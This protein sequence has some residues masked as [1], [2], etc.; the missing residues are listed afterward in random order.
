MLMEMSSKLKRISHSAVV[1]TPKRNHSAMAHTA[2][3]DSKP[4]NSLWADSSSEI[5]Y[6]SSHSDSYDVAIIGGG[7]SGLWSAYHLLKLNPDLSIV[8]FEAQRIGFGA[9]GRNGGW[10]SS[11]YPVY[12]STDLHIW[13]EKSELEEMIRVRDARGGL[14]NPECATINPIGLV[15]GLSK[16]LLA[17]GVTICESVYATA[18]E[19]GVLANSSLVSAPI[20]IQATEVFGDHQREFIPLYSLMVATQPLTDAQWREI[21][22]D[23]RFTFAEGSHLINY[24]Q[25]TADNRLA[26]GGR[27]ATYPLNS[28]LIPAKEM[29][30][31]V[32]ESLRN[33]AQSWFPALRD[34]KFTHAWGGAV[35]ITRNWEPYVHFDFSRG[36]G[37]LGGYA[38]DGVTMSYLA[39]KILAHVITGQ[40]NDLTNLHFV[41]KKIRKWEPE[42]LRYIAVNSMVKLSGIADKEEART[43]RPS[44]VSRIIAP[45]ILR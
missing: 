42:P 11:D 23:S 3:P 13:K 27:G 40:K 25:R 34:V 4:N 41:N 10:A 31:S 30:D 15:Q 39:S 26:I 33:L 7:F 38:G 20:V 12:R 16:Y 35:A 32:H 28:R 14:F 44:L 5:S 19:D 21:G 29:T 22:V 36:F 9:S 1:A 6:S 17:K 18:T 37:R 2:K 43:G 8:I 45:L 24:A